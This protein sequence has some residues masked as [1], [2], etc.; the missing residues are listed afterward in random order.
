MKICL[1]GNIYQLKAG[2]SVQRT[3]LAEWPDNIRLDGQQQRKDRRLLSSWAI[4]RWTNGLG[5]EKMNVDV[6]GDQYRLWDVDNCDT[7]YPSQIVL[8]P[9]FNACALSASKGDLAFEYLGELYFVETIGTTSRGAYKFT[10]PNTLGYAGV[11]MSN[12][13]EG[14]IKDIISIG[15]NIYLLSYYG[16]DSIGYRVWGVPALGQAGQEQK[17]VG[18]LASSLN[19]FYKLGNCGGTL[20]LLAQTG[21]QLHFYL[22]ADTLSGTLVS[23]ATINVVTG[24]Y[25]APMVT[26]GVTMYAITPKGVY[27]FDITPAIKIDTSR[28]ADRNPQQ[29]MFGNYLHFK[30]KK[31]LMKYDGADITSVGY[32]L[33]DGLPSAQWGEITAMTSSWKNIFAAVKG[34][35]YSHILSIDKDNKWQYYAK[36]PSA[37]IWVKELFLSDA[38]DAIDRLW[39]IFGNHR[40][41]GYFLN[42]MVNP[43]QAGTY[44]Y[45]GTGH[46]TPPIYDGGMSEE[47][48]GFYD[49]ITTGRD[50]NAN[51]K[52]TCLYG[53]EGAS[54]VT[55]LGVVATSP[56]ALM[57]GSPYGVEGYRIQPKF[58]LT[59]GSPGISPAYQSAILHYLKIPKEREAFDFTIDLN[60]TARTEVRPLEAVI[61]SL[62]YER[63]LRTLMPFWYGQIGTKNVKVVEMP[64]LEEITEDKI[65][66]G[67]RTGQITVRLTELL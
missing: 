41:P 35:T 28:S 32:D 17:I 29:V 51:N 10:P 30:N 53:L 56:Q 2:S 14:W 40:V 26:D 1:N 48:G 37:G 33:E 52:I 47:L 50:I 31:S 45:V 7:R 67:E 15:A 39:C 43:L 20:H 11:V 66:E 42:P 36:V 4:D 34:A 5:L 8:S 46:F 3:P 44:S 62:N 25:L 12:A 65:F 55:T 21:N 6:A 38:P 23:V 9:A 58:M 61:G 63:G 49:I 24:S 27:D 19:Y 16:A 57:F 64:S 22:G 59:G 18:S 60:E 54:P 13:D